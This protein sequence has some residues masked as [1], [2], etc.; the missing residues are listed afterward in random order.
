MEDAFEFLN[1]FLASSKFAAGDH[2][3]VADI[4]LIATISSYEAAS[5]DFSK[6]AN[7]TRW[8]AATK[9]VCPGIA[10]NEAGVEQFKNFFKK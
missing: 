7:V 2:L 5:F 9:A 1:T 8:Y 4:A 6:Y 10:I 3:T